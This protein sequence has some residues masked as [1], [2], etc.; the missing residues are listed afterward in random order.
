MGPL[1]KHNNELL[2]LPEDTM[3]MQ[4]IEVK[5]QVRLG[6]ID[7]IKEGYEYNIEQM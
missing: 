7:E 3:P 4:G 2:R 1:R 5:R 6:R